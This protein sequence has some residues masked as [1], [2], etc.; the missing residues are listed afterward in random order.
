[1]ATTKFWAIKGTGKN[2]QC[3]MDYIKNPEK[4]IP[5]GAKDV[6]KTVMQYAVNE[7]KTEHSMY[8]SGVNCSTDNAYNEFMFTKQQFNKEDVQ[9]K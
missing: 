6:L 3:V 1:M 2:L 9:H 7:D 5:S 8:V 4:T